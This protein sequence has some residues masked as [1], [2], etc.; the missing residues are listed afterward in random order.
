[1]KRFLSLS[2]A[3]AAIFGVAACG[4]DNKV[5]DKALLDFEE[6]AGQRLGEATTTTTA[7]DEATTTDTTPAA[8]TATTRAGGQTGATTKPT[9]TTRPTA[10]TA[11]TATTAPTA[12]APAFNLEIFINGDGSSDPPFDPQLARVFVGSVVRWTNK[13]SVPRQVVFEGGKIAPSPSIPPGGTFDYKATVVSPDGEP[14]RYGDGGRPYVS[15]FL[16]VLPK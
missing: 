8:S 2:L 15:A 5:G 16:E 12:A 11:T 7:L 6:Q 9:A 10:A 13:D 4:D 3:V 1:M 14:F